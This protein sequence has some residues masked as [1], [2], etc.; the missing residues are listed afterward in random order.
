MKPTAVTQLCFPV[1]ARGGW[2]QGKLDLTAND[3]G[4]LCEGRGFSGEQTLNFCRNRP[5]MLLCDLQTA[6]RLRPDV[7]AA[8]DGHQGNRSGEFF[9]HRLIGESGPVAPDRIATANSRAVASIVGPHR[10]NNSTGVPRGQYGQA[11]IDGAVALQAEPSPAIPCQD[12]TIASEGHAPLAPVEGHRL[13]VGQGL[14][15]R[16]FHLR[17]CERRVFRR[18]SILFSGSTTLPYDRRV[19]D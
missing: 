9:F 5:A 16:L 2:F 4:G 17:N 7:G 6:R 10:T 1:V 8:A 19:A 14:H 13:A 3:R 15:D 18:E 12:P 11:M